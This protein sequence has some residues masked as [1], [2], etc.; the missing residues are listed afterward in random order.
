MNQPANHNAKN[1][2]NR[3]DV[4][5]A[6]LLHQL[7]T[8]TSV[9]FSVADFITQPAHVQSAHRDLVIA[10]SRSLEIYSYQNS[11]YVLSFTIPLYSRITALNTIQIYSNQ[12]KSLVYTLDDH[13]CYIVHYSSNDFETVISF[14][15][16]IEKGPV[17]AQ[18]GPFLKTDSHNQLLVLHTVQG[19]LH[20]VTF[21]SSINTKSNVKFKP[22]TFKHYYLSIPF[23]DITSIE[24]VHSEYNQS[25]EKAPILAISF[26]KPNKASTLKIYSLEQNSDL[27]LSDSEP[28]SLSQPKS[29]VLP[30]QY[31]GSGFLVFNSSQMRY[32]TIKNSF[33]NCHKKKKHG[34]SKFIPKA[35]LEQTINLPTRTYITYYFYTEKDRL[36]LTLGTKERSIHFINIKR[37]SSNTLFKVETQ[38]T[39]EIPFTQLVY[40][41]PGAVFVCNNNGASALLSIDIPSKQH[42]ILKRFETIGPIFDYT[43]CDRDIPFYTCSTDGHNSCIT[44]LF[45]GQVMET[46]NSVQCQPKAQNVWYDGNSQC[47]ILSYFDSTDTIFLFDSQSVLT[48]P[49]TASSTLAYANFISYHIQVT[50]HAVF[51]QDIDSGMMEDVRAESVHAFITSQFVCLSTY[52]SV[53]LYTHTL[54]LVFEYTTS[55][56]IHDIMCNE[57]Y[58]VISL[59]QSDKQVIFRIS[60]LVKQMKDLSFSVLRNPSPFFVIPIKAFY[61]PVWLADLTISDSEKIQLRA[62]QSSNF[63]LLSSIMGTQQF[64]TYIVRYFSNGAL[65]IVYLDDSLPDSMMMQHATGHAKSLEI[66]T[67]LP[68]NLF[69]SDGVVY[70]LGETSYCIDL[71][72]GFWTGTAQELSLELPCPTFCQ[73]IEVGSDGQSIYVFGNNA[74]DLILTNPFPNRK[75]L[76]YNQKLFSG[77][78]TKIKSS[79]DS[80]FVVSLL[81][82]VSSTVTTQSVS[83]HEGSSL[84]ILDALSFDTYENAIDIAIFWI[85]FNRKK[86]LH[87]LVLC[88]LF[89]PAKPESKAVVLY[90][91][92][93]ISSL[94]I[95]ILTRK[96]LPEV[97]VYLETCHSTCE[98]TISE[99]ERLVFSLYWSNMKKVY[100]ILNQK[101][102]SSASQN[103]PTFYDMVEY[104]EIDILGRSILDGTFTSQD[105][106]PFAV[107]NNTGKRYVLASSVSSKKTENGNQK[108]KPFTPPPFIYQHI[109]E[110]ITKVVSLQRSLFVENFPHLTP[111]SVIATASGALYVLFSISIESPILAN[112]SRFGDLV[113]FHEQKSSNKGRL[114][115]IIEGHNLAAADAGVFNNTPV[116][117]LLNS[118]FSGSFIRHFGLD[119]I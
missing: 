9:L 96:Y 93:N 105:D 119:T 39:L 107:L 49:F 29:L 115:A 81:N 109:S 100:T 30:I 45:A 21:S 18:F 66:P 82:K 35:N 75:S 19:F 28:I 108:Y 113:T 10:R 43:Q 17:A 2:V 112:L 55:E 72:E 1:N 84:E 31:P 110:P 68:L 90:C 60:E 27:Q 52:S 91:N 6:Y 106:V 33:L 86:D 111:K 78:T 8:P 92:F 99:S 87:F 118:K 15:T 3:F 59:W 103:L 41:S 94:K 83:I 114:V 85:S 98:G 116:D 101:T 36:Y 11:S 61:K 65:S 25:A 57:K 51:R 47:L 50:P 32:Y 4:E 74:G 7:L 23:W 79:S 71:R 80:N 97:P 64:M 88:E 117:D 63:Y 69:Y 34:S 44:R 62:S 13:K 26:T 67:R 12:P 20:I 42:K 104:T 16:G 102:I 89:D 48:V 73:S 5:E 76:V 53:F 22:P 54:E 37:K 77:V 46:L 70:C 24:L 38:L 56:N 95:K 14:T 40:C 58:L